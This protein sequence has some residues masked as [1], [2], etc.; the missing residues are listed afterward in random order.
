[1]NS[2]QACELSILSAFL[3]VCE[4]LELRCFLV[5]GSAL[6][7]VK[8]GGFIPWD[9]DI[10]AALPRADYER[11]LAHAPALLPGH[12]FLQNYRTDPGFPQIY[13]KLRDSRTTC[14]E[15]SAAALPIHHGIGIDIFPLD[16]Y[17][18]GKWAQFRLELGKKWYLHL[19]GAAFAPPPDLLHRLEYRLKQ[20]LGLPQFTPQI[21]ARYDAL[22]R[23]YPAEGSRLWCNHG[24]WQGRREYFPQAQYGEGIPMSFETLTVRVPADFHSYLIQKYGNYRQ[25]PPKEKQIS[26]HRYTLVD[27]ETPYTHYLPPAPRKPNRRNRL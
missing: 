24:N 11:F 12:L 7:A 21:A 23:H 15:E 26:H 3:D 1:M 19:L 22:L 25:D 8:Y 10:D 27:C 14:I 9:D 18:E 16:G 4:T 13:S 6:G 20:I 2:L 17:P 5:C